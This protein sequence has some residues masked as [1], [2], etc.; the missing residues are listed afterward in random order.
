M[1][2]AGAFICF[3]TLLVGERFCMTLQGPT[4]LGVSFECGDA[5]IRG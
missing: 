4:D 5:A 1:P 3:M 2:A